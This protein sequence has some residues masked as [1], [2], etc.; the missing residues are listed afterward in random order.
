MSDTL[1]DFL[2]AFA[3][4]EPRREAVAWAPDARVV[5][6]LTRGE[7]ADFSRLAAWRLAAA[8][9]R[10]GTR[11]GL[12]CSNRI[13]WLPIAFGAFQLGAVLVP[14]S[15]LWKR[16]EIAYALR[17]A[18][19]EHLVTLAGF[20]R[21][22]YLA[23]LGE[24]GIGTGA[25]AAADFPALRQVV[26]LG[27]AP[28]GAARWDDLP[29]GAPALDD[30]HPTD[31]ATIF[32]TSGTTAQAKAV[33]HSHRALV[34]AAR[35]IAG[36]LGIGPDDAWWGHMPLFWSGGFVLGALATLAGG[37]R[38]VLQETV[39]PG[40][41]LELLAAEGCTIMAGWHQAGALL[42]HPAFDASRLRLRKGTAHPL[43]E[44]LLGPEHQAVGC[45]G[46]SETA[47]FV[48]A[49]R[50]DD[51]A[52]IRTGTFGRPLPG[53]EIRIVDP[54]TGGALGR[55]ETGE[56]AVRGP[57]LMEG[58][59]GVPR[60]STLDADGFFR[61]GDLGHLDADG[62]LHFT[63][64]L[65]DVIKT[66]GVNVA[67]TEVEATLGRHPAVHAAHVVGVPHPTRGENV[68]AFVAFRPGAAATPDEL[69]DF[70]RASLA[71]YKVPRHVLAIA[72]ADVPRT[73]SGRVE[74]ATLR[75]LA[76]E[77]LAADT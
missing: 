41:A 51:P 72:E 16:D 30:V 27:D 7:L 12:L 53:T 28:A 77:R 54:E 49:A 56:I 6:R 55:G 22:D 73:A 11:V 4:T 14:L 46:M 66:A 5:A 18:E 58:Y 20:R 43:A 44:R 38:I 23:T 61:T 32:F 29:G 33:V 31:V 57:T 21:H 10:R 45:Y 1:G 37:G 60:E 36:A 15:T 68:V 13:E 75:R 39:E 17:H 76:A 24:L 50:F 65:K 2:D 34:T 70:C 42:E 62:H 47:T 9:V 74:K 19:V 71:A 40:A 64:R 3:A 48:S 8:G 67:A 69:R 35:G 25:V 59:L 52:P 26:V 63:G